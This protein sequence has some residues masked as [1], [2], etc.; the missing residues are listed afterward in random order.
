M[1]P[2][3]RE[4]ECSTK[5][6]ATIAGGYAE[7]QLRGAQRVLTAEQGSRVIVPTLVFD[8]SEGL[9][10]TLPHDDLLVVGMKVASTIVRKILID[11]RSS[12]DIIMWDCLRKL[13]HPRREI[14]PLVHPILGF[15]EQEV[16]ILIIIAVIVYHSLI[17]FIIKGRHLTVQRRGRLITQTVIISHGRIDVHQLRVPTLSP[18]LTMVLNIVDVRLKIAL[19]AK[20]V[21]SQGHQEFPKELCMALM[22]PLVALILDLS[23]FFDSR[24]SLGLHSGVGFFQLALQLPPF[25]FQGFFLL[26][27]LLPVVLRSPIYPH[28]RPS[29]LSRSWIHFSKAELNG[30]DLTAFSAWAK[31]WQATHHPKRARALD[32]ARFS[33]KVDLAG[34]SAS[35]KSTARAWVFTEASSTGSWA[36][37]GLL[38]ELP[39][40]GD[41]SA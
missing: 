10:F 30:V 7:A 12:V 8:K 38:R 23:R 33:T 20:S 6:M 34:R 13:K 36:A 4:E 9:N 11:T 37:C 24:S 18:G 40:K 21:R 29:E 16:G 22:P 2:K 28:R 35:K 17:A 41:L 1:Q 15:G 39:A 27:Q 31:A 14:V 5:I 25:G 26:L 19:L 32:L 3:P